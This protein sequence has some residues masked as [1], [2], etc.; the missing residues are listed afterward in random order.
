MTMLNKTSFICPHCG[1]NSTYELLAIP[2]KYKGDYVAKLHYRLNDEITVSPEDLF[3]FY[4]PNEYIVARCNN[5][6]C[7]KL[8]FWVDG[9]LAWPAG[10]GLH[11]SQYMPEEAKKVFEEAQ[12]V[13]NLSPRSACALL[14]VC[15]E[16]IVDNIG[17]QGNYPDYKDKSRLY[18]KIK[19]L[20]LN[21]NFQLLCD[22]CRC[23]GN[24]NAHSGS[25]N[26]DD[27]ETQEL[28]QVMAIMINA[29]VDS[30]IAP[31]IIA[32]NLAPK[33]NIRTNK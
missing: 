31:M 22:V 12:S 24:E 2:E 5:A 1:V 18:D 14:R 28:A 27:G 26:L 4:D 19:S 10:G 20:N 23:A 7:R 11:P 8:S 3:D 17:K 6:D 9:K 30:L 25:L 32:R 33:F 13:A 16:R 21:E 15:L 29:L